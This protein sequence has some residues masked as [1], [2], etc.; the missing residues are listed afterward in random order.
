MSALLERRQVL[1]R[2]PAMALAAGLAVQQLPAALAQRLV[3]AQLQVLVLQ[4]LALHST[5][6]V[7]SAACLPQQGH[8]VAASDCCSR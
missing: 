8:A 4:D 3:P 6:E 1:A 7:I 2:A 5:N